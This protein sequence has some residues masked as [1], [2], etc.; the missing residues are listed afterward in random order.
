MRT[1]GGQRTQP[2]SN[3]QLAGEGWGGGPNACG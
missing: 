3:S 1:W 2:Y